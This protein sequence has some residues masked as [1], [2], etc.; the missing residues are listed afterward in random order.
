MRNGIDRHGLEGLAEGHGV[1]GLGGS[2]EGMVGNQCKNVVAKILSGQECSE[3]KI[4]PGTA[5]CRLLVD[6]VFPIVL[7][8]AFH[9]QNRASF[10]QHFYRRQFLLKFV[11]Q[12]EGSR[13]TEGQR[14]DHGVLPELALVIAMKSH[15]VIVVAVEIEED[16]VETFRRA[17]LDAPFD[18]AQK[19]SPRERVHRNSRIVVSFA[20]VSV[21]RNKARLVMDLA[22]DSD[23]FLAPNRLI[24]QPLKHYFVRQRHFDFM[25]DRHVGIRHGDW[26]KLLIEGE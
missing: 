11:L 7:C 1:G 9:E 14:G 4:H 2:G 5:G 21:E 13:C 19:V 12:N 8:R 22:V 20:W 17:V 26:F 16:S 25:Q 15:A 10:E 18:L 6:P 23:C 3:R 24:H